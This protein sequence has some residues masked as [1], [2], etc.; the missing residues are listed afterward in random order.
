MALNKR[1]L[2]YYINRLGALRAR[3]DLET[4]RITLGKGLESVALDGR[5][6]DEYVAAV[7]GSNEPVAL[8]FDELKSQD[9]CT[10]TSKGTKPKS[11]CGPDNYENSGNFS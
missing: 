1:L 4:Y 8:C 7:F 5:I 10:T 6:M 11:L 3:F 9:D 2:L